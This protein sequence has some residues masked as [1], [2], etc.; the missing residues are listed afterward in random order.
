MYKLLHSW[1]NDH[2]GS[3]M[4]EIKKYYNSLSNEIELDQILEEN[5]PKK[6]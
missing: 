3:E 4:F 6:G 5:K 2:K 1:N